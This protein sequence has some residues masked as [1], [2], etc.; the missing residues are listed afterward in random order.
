M[1]L[2]FWPTC[3]TE[4]RRG[5]NQA[6][7]KAIP[8][9]GIYIYIYQFFLLFFGCDL[10]LAKFRSVLKIV[11]LLKNK[12]PTH[13]SFSTWNCV[14]LAMLWYIF[15]VYNT[16]NLYKI[17]NFVSSKAFP[18]HDWPSTLLGCWNYALINHAFADQRTNILSTS[19]F[20]NI[21]LRFIREQIIGPL[22]NCPIFMFFRLI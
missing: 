16:V 10:I 19:S 5:G 7:E 6:T 22:F 9:I 11:I 17:A 2:F 18:E 13:N 20:K 12:S 4:I 21:K 1:S 8:C 3:S 14:S 15:F